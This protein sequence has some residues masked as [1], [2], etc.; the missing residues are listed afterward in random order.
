MP[1]RWMNGSDIAVVGDRYQACALLPFGFASFAIFV[2]VEKESQRNKDE[3]TA[4]DP[5]YD[6][7]RSALRRSRSIPWGSI[8]VGGLDV[9]S[10]NIGGR[11]YCNSL[12]RHDKVVHGKRNGG[13]ISP[14]GDRESMRTVCDRRG[15]QERD[16]P[17]CISRAQPSEASFINWKGKLDL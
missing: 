10:Y 14:V 16:T 17:T 11:G 2:P 3:G 7:T 12:V 9:G 13:G 4:N 5:S 8:R 15:D 1:R 6:G